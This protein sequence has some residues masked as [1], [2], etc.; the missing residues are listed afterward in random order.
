M[1]ENLYI[2]I[3]NVT[4]MNII[5]K[6]NGHSDTLV[7]EPSLIDKALQKQGV[8]VSCAHIAS[9]ENA[10][11][12]ISRGNGLRRWISRGNGLGMWMSRRRG[13][14]E[15]ESGRRGDKRFSH[16]PLLLL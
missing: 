8:Q 10:A 4:V 12:G 2:C 1:P 3:G 16:F 5:K 14:C 9:P 6:G 7:R 11:E 13:A 15:G